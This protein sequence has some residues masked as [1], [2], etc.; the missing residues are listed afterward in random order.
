MNKD[1]NILIVED[2]QDINTLLSTL[3][4]TN[5]YNVR[6]AFSGSE[7]KM[8]IDQFDYDLVIL[9]LM[10]PGVCGEDLISHIRS[11]KTI[12]IIVISAKSSIDSRVNVLKL[13]ADDF[14]S[15]PFSN[16]EVLA[17][18]SAQ[19]R[20]YMVFSQQKDNIIK[21]KDI[22]LDSSSRKVFVDDIE[23]KL[24]LHEFDILELLMSYPKKVFT[25]E[26][27][28]TEIWNDNYLGD[29]NTINVHISNL[30]SKLSKLNPSENYIETVWGIG[31]KMY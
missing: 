5:K 14:I 4:S 26:N 3:L 15:K 29:D 2:D 17:R 30:R 19:L 9:D 23:C 6:S 28:F 18:I 22:T 8:C 1:I 11:L 7:G 20:R 27:L 16:E 13:G 21:Y 12:P 25:R 31:F 10:L 24:T